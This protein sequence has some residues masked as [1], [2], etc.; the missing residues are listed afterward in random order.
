ME[1]FLS[2]VFSVCIVKFNLKWHSKVIEK[3]S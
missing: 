1:K 3:K 2:I